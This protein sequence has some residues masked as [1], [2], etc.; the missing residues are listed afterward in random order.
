MNTWNC[1][2]VEGLIFYFETYFLAVCLRMSCVCNRMME[3]RVGRCVWEDLCDTEPKQ[4]LKL[5]LQ[6]TD[7]CNW[8]MVMDSWPKERVRKRNGPS[9]I[10]T[11]EEGNPF[12]L[13]VQRTRQPAIHCTAACLPPAV[14]GLCLVGPPGLGRSSSVGS[15]NGAICVW[16]T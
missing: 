15:S 3:V 14:A 2:S 7:V 4:F 1:K 6:R 16:S 5:C 9:H 13:R 12:F 11:G 8:S 10:P